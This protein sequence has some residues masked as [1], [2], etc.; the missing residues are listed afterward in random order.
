[1][2]LQSSLFRAVSSEQQH[3]QVK[4]HLVLLAQQQLRDTKSFLE[5]VIDLTANPLQQTPPPIKKSAASLH[6]SLP[7]RTT[8]SICV[9]SCHDTSFLSRN[10]YFID[11]IIYHQSLCTLSIIHYRNYTNYHVIHYLIE[12]LFFCFAN[13]SFKPLFTCCY[14]CTYRRKTVHRVYHY[15]NYII[16]CGHFWCCF[17]GICKCS[18]LRLDMLTDFPPKP[19]KVLTFRK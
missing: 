14:R 11:L 3:Q 5:L 9:Q 17:Y 6:I 8:V 1:M 16:I 13:L 4:C 10:V 2:S 7:G 19:S 15:G 12:K 18:K